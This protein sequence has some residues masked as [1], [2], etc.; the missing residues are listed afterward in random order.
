MQELS[1]IHDLYDKLKTSVTSKSEQSSSVNL[2]RK[3]LVPQLRSSV[4]DFYKWQQKKVRLIVRQ[5]VDEVIL[6]IL[7]LGS[8]CTLCSLVF[9]GGE[10]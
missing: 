8:L 5:N 10:Q 9:S 6:M 4:V 7:H 1:N 3:D 2:I